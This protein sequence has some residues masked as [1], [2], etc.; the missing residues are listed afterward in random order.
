MNTAILTWLQRLVQTPSVT[1][2]HAGPKALTPGEGAMTTVVA[3]AFQSLEADEIIYDP[4]LPKRDNVYGIWYGES[5]EVLLLD[6][7]MDTVGVEQMTID[8]FAGEIRD[9]RMYGRGAVDTKASLAIALGLLE[10]HIASGKKLPYTIMIA[11]SV[12]EEEGG[13]GAAA[14]ARW[15]KQRQWRPLQMVVAE[16][17]ECRPVYGHKGLVRQF[18]TV[19][20]E[21]AH[22]AQPHLGKNAISAMAQVI[23][24]LDAEHQRLQQ[25][26]A[27]GLGHGTLTVSLIEGGRGLNIVPDACQIGIDRRVIDG[28]VVDD[29]AAA[30]IALVQAASPLPVTVTPATY[31]DAFYQDPSHPWVESVTTFNQTTATSA[32]YGTNAYAYGDLADCCIVYGPGSIAQAHTADEWI[33]LSE[34]DRAADFYR[35]WWGLQS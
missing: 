23:L 31:G 8:P 30:I 16:P 18:I 5:S 7:H 2:N 26:P 32:P 22:T 11:A 19:H 29:V 6:V 17:T 25:L 33:A 34:I 1:P 35:H 14:L 13:F 27:T 21:A 3:Q 28:E 10:S 15:V 12:D 9:G 20:G 4:V 24:A